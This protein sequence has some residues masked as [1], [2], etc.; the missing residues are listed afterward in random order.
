M[1]V[2]A[3][4]AGAEHMPL[5]PSWLPK[6]LGIRLNLRTIYVGPHARLVTE[7]DRR[8]ETMGGKSNR[9]GHFVKRM[10]KRNLQRSELSRPGHHNRP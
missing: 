2:A 8:L 5:G 7:R 6:K 4:R 9:R 10:L 3:S 1:G